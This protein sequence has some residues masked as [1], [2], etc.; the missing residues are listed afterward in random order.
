MPA[1]VSIDVA[2]ERLQFITL[3]DMAVEV[4]LERIMLED[5]DSVERDLAL[6]LVQGY[7]RQFVIDAGGKLNRAG[8]EKALIIAKWHATRRL[9]SESD[10]LSGLVERSKLF[11]LNDAEHTGWHHY[12][13]YEDVAELLASILEGKEGSAEAYDWKFVVEQLLPAAQKAEIPAKW[14]YSASLNVKKLRG[15]VP[16]ARELLKRQQENEIPSKEAEQTLKNWLGKT[17]DPNVSFSGLHEELNQWRGLSVNRK[18]PLQGHQIM[19]P[20]GNYVIVIETTSDRD[21]SM[22]EQALKNRVNLQLTGFDLLQAMVIGQTKR[23]RLETLYND[24]GHKN[25]EKGEL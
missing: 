13:E 14:L 24:N 18:E 25:L 17:V 11:M 9:A 16:A 5:Y 4:N 2:L 22:V 6:F 15:M 7:F 12:M 23:H 20:D 21:V 8:Q 19:M 1:E 10:G 3:E